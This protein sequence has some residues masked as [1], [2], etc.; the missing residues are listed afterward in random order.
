MNGKRC[1]KTDILSRSKRFHK[2]LTK[3]CRTLFTVLL[4]LTLL[5]APVKL[6]ASG[7]VVTFEHLTLTDTQGTDHLQTLH[8]PCNTEQ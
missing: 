2:I 6:C 8:E 3:E 4:F 1:K 5:S 7:L